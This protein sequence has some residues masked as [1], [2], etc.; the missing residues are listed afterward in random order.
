MLYHLFEFLENK[1]NLPGAG[2]FQFIS[3]RSAIAVILSLIITILFGKKIIR[4]LKSL[5]VGESVR[6]L[7]LAG[8]TE[9]SGTPTMGGL[10]IIFAIIVPTILLA[11][12]DNIYII[13][14][15]IT[16][17]WIA[18]IGFIDDYIK[19][20]RKD[21]KGLQGRFKIVGQVT[22]GILVGLI[23]LFHNDVTVRM[24]LD[25]A[26]QKGFDV[27]ETFSL[28]IPKVNSLPETRQMAYVK[29]PITNLPFMKKNQLNYSYFSGGSKILAS[30]LFIAMV[31]FIITAVSNGANLTDGLDGLLTGVAAII[32]AALGVLAY[33]SSN[34]IT[35]D[36]LNIFYLPHSEELV[37][38]AA[39]FLG[40]CIGFLWYNSYPASVFMGDTGSLTIGGI[41]AVMAIILRKELLIPVLCGILFM[42]TLSVVLQ[43]SYFK[44]SK[45][46]YGE[47]RR[48]FL[49]SP[50]HHHYQ[51]KG[52]HEVK[53]VVR[54]W[55][56][57]II[58]AVLTIITLKIR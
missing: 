18:G 55:I 9:K 50:L 27:V 48:L 39:C 56:I 25:E 34:S 30:L 6:D 46:K 26:Q 24:P 13:L 21:K 28:T 32:G 36:Y 54:F 17:V 11:R 20:F 22:L 7:G 51:K 53:I 44:Y 42:E 31:I 29:A 23:M 41:I 49:M 10:I 43:V 40:A 15:L 4:S 45:R 19:V 5:Q 57:A 3:F 12:L 47:G 35:A 38:F 14:M 58:L 37:I 52:I 1:F 16:T 8:Q 33:V 2:L